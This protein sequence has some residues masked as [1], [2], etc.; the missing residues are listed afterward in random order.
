MAQNPRV[1]FKKLNHAIGE[2][3]SRRKGGNMETTIM[4]EDGNFIVGEYTIS[5]NYDD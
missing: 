5:G 3:G 1:F 4:L 2:Y